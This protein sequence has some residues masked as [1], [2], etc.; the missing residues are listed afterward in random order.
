MTKKEEFDQRYFDHMIQKLNFGKACINKTVEGYHLTH[1][2]FPKLEI[3][4]KTPNLLMEKI[5]NIVILDTD[6]IDAFD[7]FFNRWNS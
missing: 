7:R 1:K 6:S 5:K 4:A 3:T 2:E